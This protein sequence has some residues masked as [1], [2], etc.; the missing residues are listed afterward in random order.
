MSILIKQFISYLERLKSP[1]TV[2]N[3]SLYLSRFLK[4]IGDKPIAD[5]TV[6]DVGAYHQ[7]LN[8]TNLCKA[9]ISFHI[10]AIR[11]LAIFCKK[12]EIR[13][14]KPSSIEIPKYVSKRVECMSQEEAHSVMDAM[15]TKTEPELRDKALLELLYSTG[16]RIGEVYRLNIINVDLKNREFTILGKGNIYRPVF[17]SE[18]AAFWIKKYINTRA[19]SNPALFISYK[20]GINRLSIVSMQRIVR[21]AAGS[22]HRKIT[23]HTFRHTFATNLLINGADIMA[24]KDMLGHKFLS[25][26]QMYLHYNNSTLHK[27]F[28]IN[29]S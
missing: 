18:R 5:I 13:F 25:T 27:V 7:Y 28:D 9:T 1:H 6:S 24:V 21:L 29:H 22:L 12:Y 4:Y 16:M 11:S 3:Y 17:L 20:K 8:S 23:P 2:T 26:T 19:D 14:L 15:P 10:A